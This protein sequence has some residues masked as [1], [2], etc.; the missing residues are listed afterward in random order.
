VELANVTVEI[1]HCIV[2]GLR[3]AKEANVE[4]RDS[5]V[6]ATSETAVAYAHTDGKGT[7]GRLQI[8]DSTVIGKVHTVEMQSASN[9]IFMARLANGDTWTAP[10]RSEKKQQGCVRFSYVP[11]GSQTPRRYRCQPDLEIA[12][13]AEQAE[14]KAQENNTTLSEADRAA[15]RAG[16]EAWLVPSFTSTRYGEPGY[17]QLR[18]GCP[19]QIRTGAD[20]ESE[21]GAFHDLYQPQR[22]TNLRVRLEE[23]LRFGLEAGIFYAT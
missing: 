7:G 5:I 16:V 15:I 20:D 1:D 22:E 6:D 21:M 18:L 3:I 12:R 17:A 14:E 11:P 23:Y 13:Q 8:V 9:T 4:I 2:G 19:I 10:I